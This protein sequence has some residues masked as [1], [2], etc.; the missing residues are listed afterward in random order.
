[1]GGFAFAIFIAQNGERLGEDG[2]NWLPS[3]L[4]VGGVFKRAGA[5]GDG[6]FWV[7]ENKL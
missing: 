5:A 3:V 2:V 6:I 7:L 4:F 1:L